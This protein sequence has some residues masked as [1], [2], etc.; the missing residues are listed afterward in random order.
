MI[1]SF[2]KKVRQFS[3]FLFRSLL[4]MTVIKLTWTLADSQ[5]FIDC[6]FIIHLKLLQIEMEDQLSGDCEREIFVFP[7]MPSWHFDDCFIDCSSYISGPI[8]M[9]SG[10]RQ[11]ENV[12]KS[13]W[14]H[15]K[16]QWLTPQASMYLDS[17]K[18][19]IVLGQCFHQWSLIIKVLQSVLHCSSIKLSESIILTFCKKISGR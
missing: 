7:A 10:F 19:Y 3:S 4:L 14:K 17:D 18:T 16:T 2:F 12:L 5:W 8:A 6:S 9:K 11:L 15:L 1:T 13:L